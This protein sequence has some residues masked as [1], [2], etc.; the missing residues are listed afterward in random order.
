MNELNPTAGPIPPTIATPPRL[1]KPVPLEEDPADREPITGP[2]TAVEAVL[3]APRRI[4][5]Q[6]RQP[7]SGQ[8]I[9]EMLLVSLVCS[10]IYGLMV[11]TFSMGPQLLAAPVKIADGLLVSALI[12]LP[13]LYIFTCFSGS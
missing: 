10:L 3:R 7:S 8:L 11:G 6:L 5:Y 2:L 9:L 1:T 12:C 13:N 4:M